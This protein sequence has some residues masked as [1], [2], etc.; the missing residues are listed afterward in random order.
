MLGD[1]NTF[2]NQQPGTTMVHCIGHSLGGAIANLA[3]EWAANTLNKKVKLYTF[4]SPRVGFAS[5]GFA[6]KLTTALLPENIHRVYHNNDPVPMI[7]TFP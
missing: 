1:I 4:G 5:G 2:I 3:A 7:P 6:N